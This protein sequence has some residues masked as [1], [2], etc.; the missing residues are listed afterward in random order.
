ME[1]IIGFITETIYYFFIITILF[2]DFTY[3]LKI[4]I[5]FP[6]TLHLYIFNIID[7][8]IDK[9]FKLLSKK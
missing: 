1:I 4:V 2:F 7:L 3:N 5:N 6:N 9:L 8:C